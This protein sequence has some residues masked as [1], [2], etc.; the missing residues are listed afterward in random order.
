M[1]TLPLVNIVVESVPIIMH[2]GV[3]LMAPERIAADDL[4]LMVWLGMQQTT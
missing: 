1:E 3:Q 4:H 2:D